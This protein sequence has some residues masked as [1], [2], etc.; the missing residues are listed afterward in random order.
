M[1]RKSNVQ[2]QHATNGKKPSLPSLDP[3]EAAQEACRLA[4]DGNLKLAKAVDALRSGLELIVSAEVDH[5]TGLLVEG[6]VLRTFAIDALNA[7][8]TICGQ[9]WKLPRNKL[10]GP[11]R[12]GDKTLSTL[13]A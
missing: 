12:A 7:Y 1:P 13:E 3:L 9:N 2:A 4:Q 8:S 5:E 10:S 11:T 6:R